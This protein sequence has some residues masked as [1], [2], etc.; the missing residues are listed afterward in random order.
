[1]LRQFFLS[2][3][4]TADRHPYL[5]ILNCDEDSEWRNF[6]RW[7]KVS[8]YSSIHVAFIS[9]LFLPCFTSSI[10]DGY[11]RIFSLLH[12]C[13]C[14][15]LLTHNTELTMASLQIWLYRC[16]RRGCGTEAR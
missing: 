8:I 2:S 9:R 3:L 7:V 14:A 1:M 11:N 15:P 12:A 4:Y 5:S 13:Y 6:V 10:Y 16:T